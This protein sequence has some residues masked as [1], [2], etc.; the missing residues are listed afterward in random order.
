MLNING[1]YDGLLSFLDHAMEKGFLPLTTCC[2][3]M[4]SLTAKRLI[5]KLKTY[6]PKPNPLVKHT[7]GQSSNSS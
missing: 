2:T 6:A 1:F 3:I 5:Y 4:S 7:H